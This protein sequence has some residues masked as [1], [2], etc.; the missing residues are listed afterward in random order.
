MQT[1][2]LILYVLLCFVW[3]L[4]VSAQQVFDFSSLNAVVA[5]EL[6]QTHTPGA[7]VA[8]VLGERLLVSKGFGVS[9]VETETP[10]RPEMLFRLGST[11]KMFTATALVILAE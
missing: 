1:R 4:P 3:A 6:R 8:V 10:V 9:D 7:A 5:D 11:T 2:K